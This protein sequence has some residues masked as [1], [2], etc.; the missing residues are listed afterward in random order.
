MFEG[1]CRIEAQA[2]ANHHQR[3]IA[4]QSLWASG[5]SLAIAAPTISGWVGDQTG[6]D[7]VEVNVGG[8]GGEG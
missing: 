1:L 6:A 8:D 7:G 5:H 4:V 2:V 3:L